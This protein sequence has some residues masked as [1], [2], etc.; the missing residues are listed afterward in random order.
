[1]RTT[2]VPFSEIAPLMERFGVWRCVVDELPETHATRGFVRR[3]RNRVYLSF[4]NENQRGV[5]KWDY[6]D[7]RWR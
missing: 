7:S 1:M 4:F 3:H 5:P 2:R 6:G